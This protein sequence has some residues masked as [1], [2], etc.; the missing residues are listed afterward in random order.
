MTEK[1]CAVTVFV[2][3]STINMQ[4]NKTILCK[5]KKKII[6]HLH[7]NC[8]FSTSTGWLIKIVI[9]CGLAA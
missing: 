6:I 1:K 3:C 4:G 9:K 8:F 7:Y 5:K 2:F